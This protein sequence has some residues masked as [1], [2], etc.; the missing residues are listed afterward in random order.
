MEVLK[1]LNKLEILFQELEIQYNGY[2]KK[3]TTIDDLI[4]KLLMVIENDNFNSAEAYNYC[5][6]LKELLIKKREIDD[7]KSKYQKI[8]SI[9]TSKQIRINI[10]RKEKDI[11]NKK[12]TSRFFHKEE[13]ISKYLNGN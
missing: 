8:L 12:Y 3:G 4:K 6:I 5:K 10:I 2:L 9:Y 13:D 1:V 11:K 7:L